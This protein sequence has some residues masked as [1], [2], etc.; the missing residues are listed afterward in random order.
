[1]RH[2]LPIL[3]ATMLCANAVRAQTEGD[4]A[5]LIDRLAALDSIDVAKDV[6]FREGLEPSLGTLDADESKMTVLKDP[7]E[8]FGKNK[9]VA[10]GWYR[11]SFTVP[12]KIGKFEVPKAG[13]NLGVESN[14]LGAWEIY[15]WINGKPAGTT[16]ASGVQRATVKDFVLSTSNQPA[17][18]WMSNAPLPCKPGD[19]LTVAILAMTSPLGKGSPEGYGLRHLRLRFAL[20]H[21]GARQPF[22]G[23]VKDSG[24]YAGTGLLGA[25]EKLATLKGDE[26]AALQAKLK[27]PLANLDAV[28]A[29]AETGVLDNLTKAMQTATKEINEALKPVPKPATK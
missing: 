22:F 27:Q 6:K 21:T 1:M 20:A 12:E 5:A 11:V 23:G 18:A 14:V 29:A 8:I 10:A 17:T 4:L 19:K 28:F 25:R 3:I 26:L 7:Y 13:Y 24:Y 16:M 2:I 15:T 9:P